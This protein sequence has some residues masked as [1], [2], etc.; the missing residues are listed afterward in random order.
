MEK[1][2]PEKFKVACNQQ[3]ILDFETLLRRNTFEVPRNSPLERAILSGSS[4]F[5]MGKKARRDVGNALNV[6]ARGARPSE[7][8]A[9]RERMGRSPACFGAAIPITNVEE[10]N[11][12][13]AEGGALP[14]GSM[15]SLA[16]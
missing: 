11:V 14:N 1:K 5:V 16:N 3:V 15:K 4:T 10:A 6:D 9:L 12:L 7:K 8:T 2:F 13:T